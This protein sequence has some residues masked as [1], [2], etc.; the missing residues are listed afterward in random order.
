M[1][2]GLRLWLAKQNIVALADRIHKTPD[3]LYRWRRGEGHPT[4]RTAAILIRL[5]RGHLGW[6]DIYG[7]LTK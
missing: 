4:P 5:A 7:Y 3:C 2:S 6:D 1:Q